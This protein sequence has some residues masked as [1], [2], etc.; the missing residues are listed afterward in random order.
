MNDR[1]ASR[2]VLVVF[3]GTLSILVG[4]SILPGSRTVSPSILHPR[5]SRPT[6]SPQG[7]GKI[8]P[9]ATTDLAQ[10]PAVEPQDTPPPPDVEPQWA[11]P[12]AGEPRDV[13]LRLRGGDSRVELANT[14]GLLDPRGEFTVEMW[15][16]VNHPDGR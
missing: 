15:A 13:I 8:D 11:K 5:S 2:L 1:P 3:V 16:H 7:T 12:G 4:W 9:L 14:V 10:L 6:V